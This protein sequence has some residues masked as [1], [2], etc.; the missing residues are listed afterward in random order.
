MARRLRR[1]GNWA[2]KRYDSGAQA[3]RIAELSLLLAARGLRTPVGFAG[4]GQGEV[5]FLW[6]AGLGGRDLLNRQP[7]TVKFDAPDWD[8]FFRR[9]LAPLSR[10]HGISPA[11]LDLNDHDPYAKILP[12]LEDSDLMADARRPGHLAVVEALEELRQALDEADRKAAKPAQ[13]VVHGDFHVGQVHLEE[14][15]NRT[16]LL[17][18]DDLAL[19]YRESDLGNFAAHLATS[20][21]FP[22]GEPDW[23]VQ[24]MVPQV[25]STYQDLANHSPDEALLLAYAGL[26][27]LRRALKFRELKHPLPDVAVLVTAARALAR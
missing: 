26:A 2:R 11:G 9:M 27:L 13:A 12:R 21:A 18:L 5:S 7:R 1:D 17:D 15:K 3:Q 10:L 24:A 16:W 4:P 22:E 6:I 20:G 8:D 14:A 25:Q 19:S 23:V